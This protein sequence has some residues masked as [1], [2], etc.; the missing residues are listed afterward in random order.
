MVP[1]CTHDRAS[2]VISPW[3]RNVWAAISLT[4]EDADG[5]E[6]SCWRPEIMDFLV[7]SFDVD[8]ESYWARRLSAWIPVIGTW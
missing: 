6:T 8:G 2:F 4:V 1:R 7:A 3:E 5:S